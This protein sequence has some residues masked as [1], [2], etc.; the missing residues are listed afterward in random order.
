MKIDERIK[1]ELESESE[2]LD[3]ILAQEPGLFGQ[4][5]G[6]FKGSLRGWVIFVNF[7][8]I[9]FTVLMFWSG[10]EFFVAGSTDNRVFWGV[11]ALASIKAQVSLKEWLFSEMR[12]NSLMREIKRLELS[13]EHL[14]QKIES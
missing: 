4:V 7:I 14:Q 5:A 3:K 6:I 2:Q 9:I 12:R 8:I 13:I 11:I 1:K 10:Y